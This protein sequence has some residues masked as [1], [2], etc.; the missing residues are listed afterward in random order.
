MKRSLILTLAG[1]A[2]AGCVISRATRRTCSFAGKIVLITGGSRGLGLVM[3]RQFCAEG[4]QVA[5]LARDADQ[6]ARARDELADRGGEV[7]TVSCDL[8]D[9][10]QIEKA[11]EEVA[12]HFGGIDVVINNAGIIEVGPLEHM[13]REDFQRA[14]NLHFWAPFDLIM[15]ALPY[16]RRRAGGRIVNIAS[17]GGRMA[18]PHLAPYCA[19]KFA[20]VGLS[21]ALPAELARDRIDVTTVTPGLMRTGS[22]GNAKFK[23]DHLAE[24]TW[25]SLSTALPFASIS[26]EHAAA[27]IISACR[28]GAPSL[29]IPLAAH[30]TIL[31]NALFPNIAGSV[32]KLINT[33]LLPPP[34]GPDG[35]EARSGWELSPDVDR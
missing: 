21:D 6:L 30:A 16:L 22:Q 35:D 4:A 5:L 15:Q 20:L 28:R 14:M 31:G 7:M 32:M 9:R 19:S 34:S 27:R 25:F 26:A 33:V 24:Y 1:G 17:I 12:D 13:R 2:L 29:T 23:G 3:A 18:V 8:L 11:V 10:A